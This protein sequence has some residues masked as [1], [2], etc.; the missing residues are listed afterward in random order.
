MYF[1]VLIETSEKSGK[2]EV[3]KQYYEL[4]KTNISEIEERIVYPFLR[5]EDFQFDG[6]FLKYGEIKRISIK[7]TQKSAVELAQY[8]NDHMD[9][10]IVMYVSPSDI[11]SYTEHTKDVTTAIFEKA[12][13]AVKNSPM[14][15]A[16]KEISMDRSKVFIVHGRDD[17]A[18]T[19]AARFIEKLGLTAVIL[20]EQASTGKTIIEK[21]EEYTNVGFALVLYTPCDVGSV[22]GNADTKPRAR[23]NVVFEHGYLIAKLGRKNVCALVKGNVEI[24]NDISGVVYVPFD[25]HAAWHLAVAKELRG[26]GYTIDMNKVV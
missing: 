17:L 4:D 3:M 9:S 22:L 25:T 21:I 2:N 12:K 11:V 15:K 8:E 6:Y 24:P 10:S 20:H 7:E 5:K 26:A 1:Q 19:E 14:P 18:K 23:Q 13:A 16:E